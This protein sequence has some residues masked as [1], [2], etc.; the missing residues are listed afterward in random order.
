MRKFFAAAGIA[1][2]CVLAG[3]GASAYAESGSSGQ[4]STLALAPPARLTPAP[5]AESGSSD[6]PS[7]L[8]LARPAWLTPALEAQI[9]AAGPRGVDVPAAQLD[10]N[11]IGT[12]PP[13]VGTDGAAGNAVSAGGCM[14]SPS[15]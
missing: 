14:V 15:G 8:D 4:P 7:T 6:Q 12:S 3:V 5:A 2:A 13:Y 9:V 11:C 1:V 10:P